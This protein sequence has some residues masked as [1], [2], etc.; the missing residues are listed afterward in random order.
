MLRFAAEDRR[1]RIALRDVQRVAR[2]KGDFFEGARILAQRH[3]GVSGAIQ[4]VEED[5][6][7]PLLREP[8]QVADVHD[9]RRRNFPFLSSH[10]P[11][12]ARATGRTEICA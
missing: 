9:T 10:Q 1:A 3:L 8:P 6:R 12:L 2:A 5:A 7:Q 4:I 11:I